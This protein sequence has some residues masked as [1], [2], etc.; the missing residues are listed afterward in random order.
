MSVFV[1]C[2][3]SEMKHLRQFVKD[4]QH[5]SQTIFFGHYP[6]STIGSAV[7]DVRELFGSVHI[8][9]QYDSYSEKR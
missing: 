3:Q 6:T 9:A 8:V 2:L 4:S 1:C 7:Y 5:A